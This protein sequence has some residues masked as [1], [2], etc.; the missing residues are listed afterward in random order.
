MGFPLFRL[1]L[2]C[3]VGAGAYAAVKFYVDFG[4]RFA[5][6]G[7]EAPAATSKDA[8]TDF[9]WHYLL[10]SPASVAMLGLGVVLM[11]VGVGRW[12]VP[13]GR[14]AGPTQVRRGRAQRDAR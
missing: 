7:G 10:G 14:R 13:R 3:V 1:G 2:L 11:V 5:A 6:M 8:R 12:F 4:Q 9:V